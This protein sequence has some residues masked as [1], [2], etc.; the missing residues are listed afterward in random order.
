MH[1]IYQRQII[2][3][4]L[5]IHLFSW[6]IDF[7]EITKLHKIILY[8]KQSKAKPINIVHIKIKDG[9]MIIDIIY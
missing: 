3:S 5:E 4:N 2:D 1:T 6:N 7:V 9:F 8:I